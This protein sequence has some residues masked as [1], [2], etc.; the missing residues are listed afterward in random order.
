MQRNQATAATEGSSYPRTTH[1]GVRGSFEDALQH[2]C[3]AKKLLLE[4]GSPEHSQRKS[5]SEL[6]RTGVV[7]PTFSAQLCADL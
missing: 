5:N 4:S 6:A 3:S 7:V 1:S 2:Y